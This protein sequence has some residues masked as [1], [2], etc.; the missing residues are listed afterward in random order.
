METTVDT[1]QIKAAYCQHCKGWI[2]A[3]AFPWC[4][5]SKAAVKEF[6]QHIKDGNRIELLNLT[7]W[8]AN[9]TPFCSC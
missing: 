3:A 8:E 9:K 7:E 2:R 5:T 1:R 4:E 6:K